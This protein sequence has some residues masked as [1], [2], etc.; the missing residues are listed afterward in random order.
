M[1]EMARRRQ[2]NYYGDTDTFLY[3][4]IGS[5][6]QR[7]QVCM[8]VCGYSCIHT[9][10]CIMLIHFCMML[11][12]LY[13]NACGCAC[14]YVSVYAHVCVYNVDTFLY[15]ALGSLPQSLQVC[16]YVSKYTYVCIHTY[17]C[18]SPIAGTCMC[19]CMHVCMMHVNM[20]VCMYEDKPVHVCMYTY[21]HIIY[22]L[23]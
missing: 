22:G 15:D 18:T 6:P 12:D 2:T 13:L 21:M 11:L 5:L 9:Y 7:L 8:Y 20:C 19:V 3:D 10:V 16:M 4:A 17:V 1:V 14:M 23:S